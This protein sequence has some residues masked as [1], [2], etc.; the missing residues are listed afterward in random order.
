MSV[1]I[2]NSVSSFGDGVF[3]GCFG[4]ES[5]TIPK[6]DAMRVLFYLRPWEKL[7]EIHAE[8][9]TWEE[10]ISLDKELKFP[11]DMTV[12]LKDG[13]RFGKVVEDG[14]IYYVNKIDYKRYVY[15][16]DKEITI[17][18]IKNEIDG[19]PVTYISEAA[20]NECSS[21]VSVTIP[22]NIDF[23]GDSAFAECTNLSSVDLGNG[24]K[25]IDMEAFFGCS[26][27]TSIGIPGSME[28]IDN[29]AFDFC[30]HL[31]E[32]H[33]ESFTK[34]EWR[35]IYD[36]RSNDM[37]VCLKDGKKDGKVKEEGITYYIDYDEGE[38]YV[39]AAD[40]DVTVAQ[41]KEEVEGEIVTYIAFGAFVDHT[42]LT[43]VIIPNSVTSIESIAFSGCLNLK[44]INIIKD[45]NCQEEIPSGAPWGAP[46]TA[47][48]NV[49][50]KESL[51]YDDERNL[52]Y[53]VNDNETL[54][55]KSTI[56]A[57]VDSFECN[58]PSEY[59]GISV[60]TIL[61]NAF[62]MCSNLSCINIPDSIEL[63]GKYAFS[64]C[65][66]LKSICIP[67]S[68][69]IIGEN[70][71][72]G[73]S[74]LDSVNII[75]D[76]KKIE[77]TPWG[78]PESTTIN[79]YEAGTVLFDEE[80]NFF[81][82]VVE[83]GTLCIEGQ[84]REKELTCELV[85]PS[86]YKG[87]KI[88]SIGRE[89]FVGCSFIKSMTIPKSIKSIKSGAFGLCPQAIDFYADSFTKEEW[90]SILDDMTLPTKAIVYL[91]DGQRD[92]MFIEEGIGYSVNPKTGK[93]FVCYAD[94]DIVV[95]QIKNEIEGEPVTA[96]DSSAF[97]ECSRLASVTIPE[98]VS[99]IRLGA[100]M[101]CTSLNKVNIPNSIEQIGIYAFRMCTSL[102]SINIPA[103]VKDIGFEA[104]SGCTNLTRINILNGEYELE[105]APWGAPKS[106][107]I[108]DYDQDSPIWDLQRDLVYEL[109]AKGT[110][111]VKSTIKRYGKFDKYD[112]PSE[113]AGFDVTSIEEGAFKKCANIKSIIVPESVVSIEDD[114][115]SGCT[116]L[117]EIK[118]NEGKEKIKGTPWGA[119]E[120]TVITVCEKETEI[121]DEKRNL[122]YKIIGEKTLCVLSPIDFE[123]ESWECDIPFAFNGFRVTSIIENAFKDCSNLTSIKIPAS[124]ETIGENAFEG[125][126]KLKR[127]ILIKDKHEIKGAPWGASESSQICVYERGCLLYDAG[128]ELVYQLD[129]NETL[130]V[131][132]TKDFGRETMPGVAVNKD[133]CECVIPSEFNG[134][135]I[136]SIDGYAFSCC[137]NLSSVSIPDSVT[138][139]DKG[140]FFMSFKI[141]NIKIPSSVKTIDEEAFVMCPLSNI[142]IDKQKDSIPGAP[143]GAK[144]AVVKWLED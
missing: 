135:K 29:S 53:E 67:D 125:C 41:I 22:D 120:S 97:L 103:S 126:S 75:G 42:N 61:D 104:F 140:I 27:L 76:E 34:E 95:A 12:Y 52:V 90:R 69:K 93:R 139:I 36:C 5:I 85:I 45:R 87:F 58:I 18:R 43:S 96:I 47:V 3:A 13:Q 124:I 82:K 100:F 136:T 77:G 110:L 121:Y 112:I 143:W 94:K 28:Y 74:S 6:Q 57:N 70:A 111:S 8:S 144:D 134:L 33:A 39:A 30:K 92:G 73:C 105:G 9:F 37:T 88:A 15:S 115:F 62:L 1:E 40:K 2:P 17:A 117:A 80:R 46:E 141:T 60:T 68:V 35:N 44:S 122:L 119:P 89:A 91:R 11:Y 65:S 129:E 7:K 16:A 31:S 131:K 32:I 14:I 107:E 127:I 56:E 79:Y 133:L 101:G 50:K 66:S 128:R 20:F 108:I 114:A 21:L 78:T 48:I 113:F 26:S 23:I 130:C 10:W 19:E 81:Y 63:I 116:N 137:L 71:F 51:I 24:L 54:S 72:Y 102:T 55:V 106:T 83:D 86:E 99:D 64:E 84:D 49:Y 59:N 138:H 142:E 98:S 25:S 132:G 4:I 123:K 38:R 118:I 109:T